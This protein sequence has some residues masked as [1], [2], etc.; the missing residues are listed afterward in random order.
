MR[1]RTLLILLVIGLVSA[2]GS[3]YLQTNPG[4]LDAYYYY[5]GGV[6][7]ANGEG[8]VENFLWNYLDDPAGLPHA[9][10]AYWMPL[11]SFAAALGIKVFSGF[12]EIFR[13]AQLNFILVAACIPP[14]TAL[15]AW[16]I[17][18]EQK[19]VWMSGLLAA[20]MGYYQPFI[21]A[22]DSFGTVMLVGGLF[23][24]VY[25]KVQRWRYFLLGLL[26][27]LMHLARA[28]GLLWLGVGGLAV[29][30]DRLH[31]Q[32]SRLVKAIFSKQ[33]I[34]NGLLV[35]GGYLLVMMP[36]FVRTY[37]EF[38]VPLSPGGSR[39]IWLLD[40][41]E[42]FSY[43]AG[44]LTFSHWWSAGIGELISVRYDALIVNLQ[45]SAASMGM[46]VPGGM[47]LLGMFR[48]RRHRAMQLGALYWLVLIFVMSVVFP[49]AG[50]RG[51]F[52]H[53]GA[54]LMPLI[55]VM[56]PPGIEV[57]TD[58]SVKTFKW[59]AKKIRPFYVG[60]LF[61]YVVLFSVGIT[62]TNIVGTDPEG[63]IIWDKTMRQ[64]QAVEEALMEMEVDPETVI[65]CATPPAYTV[66]NG[67]P[68]IALP[69]GGID[70][71]LAVVERYQAGFVLV[72]ESHPDELEELFYHPEDIGQLRYITTV[73]GVHIFSWEG[74]R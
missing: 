41:D 63:G 57:L 36:W 24:L 7:L 22:V 60:M 20:F 53:S 30:L 68:A 45:S 13:A 28:D 15:L 38:G 9:G 19:F 21:T 46:L 16:E 12:L 40:Y 33:V 54:A 69:D 1:K 47:A 51:G 34:R 59:Q 65:V 52:F 5:A 6:S 44:V 27:G 31:Q 8:L 29:L 56:V 3:A 32:P 26:A 2:L 71:L 74:E 61:I 23:F 14:L 62:M 72:E 50:M 70:P 42:L 37:L 17:T 55:W 18:E 49:Y 10:F 64:Y 43:P 66:L 11:T 58:W 25:V 48:F 73:E 39:A 35:L 67:R 4:Y